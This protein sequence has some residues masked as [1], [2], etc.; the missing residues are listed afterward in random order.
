MTRK[1]DNRAFNS[2]SNRTRVQLIVC[3]E[4]PKTVTELLSLCHLSQSALS[5]HLKILR[6]G[7]V[8]TCERDGKC[9]IYHVTDRRVLTI[10]RSLLKL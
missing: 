3:L 9:Q 4:K 10:A 7:G 8:V 5:Q 6:D 1:Y 2:F